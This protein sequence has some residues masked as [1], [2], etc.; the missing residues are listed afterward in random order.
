MEDGRRRAKRA[1]RATRSGIRQRGSAR[2]VTVDGVGKEDTGADDAEDAV[3]ASN[4]AKI[5]K[6]SA[7]T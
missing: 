3:T 4:M 5:P 1:A 2:A 6:P 7:S